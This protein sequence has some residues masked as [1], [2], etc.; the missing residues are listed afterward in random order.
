MFYQKRKRD[1]INEQNSLL[2]EYEILYYKTM[3]LATEMGNMCVFPLTAVEAYDWM[4]FISNEE[5][6]E[7]FTRL[8]AALQYVET[9][10]D[11]NVVSNLKENIEKSNSKTK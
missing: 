8:V 7:K 11:E 2:K 3:K 6:M 4:K 1:I 5:E 10:Q 9:P